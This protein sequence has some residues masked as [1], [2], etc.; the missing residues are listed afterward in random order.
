DD[1]T[2]SDLDLDS[3]FAKVDRTCTSVGELELYHLLRTPLLEEA[4]L[5]ERDRMIGRFE[6]DDLHR[7]HICME[8]MKLGRTPYLGGLIDL[9]WGE[10]PP[11]TELEPVYQF[12]AALAAASAA[13]A[14]V[15]WVSGVPAPALYGVC[16]LLFVVNSL[17]H[18]RTS[19]K[20]DDRTLSFHY[21]NL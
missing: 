2:W 17:V 7:E 12:L 16:L 14:A 6:T 19:S 1:H 15:L 18:Y 10:L 4:P 8:M 20:F 11:S 13:S 9:V 5:V 21:V 3:V